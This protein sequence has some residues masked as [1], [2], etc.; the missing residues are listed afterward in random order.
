VHVEDE[1]CLLYALHD[2]GGPDGPLVIIEK[3]ASAESLA[4]HGRSPAMLE[5][6]KAFA[7]RLEVAP[8][9]VRT[10]PVPVEGS[11]GAI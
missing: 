9:V 4:E 7:G 8:V 1:G 10:T 2:A 5:L 3:W 11:K 6:G